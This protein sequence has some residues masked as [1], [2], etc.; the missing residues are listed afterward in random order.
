MNYIRI[1]EIFSRINYAKSQL[2][3]NYQYTDIKG[4]I[5]LKENSGYIY[6]KLFYITFF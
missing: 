3:F 2:S 6:D 5:Y 1:L 4:C